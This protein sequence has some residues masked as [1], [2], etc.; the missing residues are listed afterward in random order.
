MVNLE[1]QSRY[2]LV[3][4][5]DIEDESATSHVRK[6]VSRR[7]LCAQCTQV[8]AICVIVGFFTLFLGY[9]SWYVRHSKPQPRI[10]C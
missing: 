1:R 7:V 5:E 3:S 8:G 4:E 2:Q 10:V 6:I 9:R